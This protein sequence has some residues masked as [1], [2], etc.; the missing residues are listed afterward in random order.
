MNRPNIILLTVD[1]LRADMLGY[2]GYQRPI[3]PNIDRFAAQSV[4]FRQAI[5]AGS[6][7]QAAFPGILTSTYAS[8]YGGCL[9]PLSTERP[10]PIKSLVENGYQTAAFST[11]PLLSKTYGYHHHIKH[12]VDLLPTEKAPFLFGLKGGQPLL[13]TPWVHRLAQLF[14]QNW[15]PPKVYPTAAELN[16]VAIQWLEAHQGEPF[17]AWLHYMDVHWPYHLEET[18]TQPNEIAAAWQDLAHLHE[19][20]WYGLPVSAAQKARYVNL[21]EQAVA[22]CDAQIGKLLAHL[23]NSGL[24]ENSVII[25]VSDHGEEFLERKHWGHVEINLYDEI[26]NVPL[27]IHVPGV[28]GQVVEQQVSTLDIMPTVLELANCTPPDGMLGTS[29]SPLWQGNPA[30]YNAEVAL[31]ERWRDDVHKIAVRSA[32]FKYIWDREKPEEIELYDL[33]VDPNETNNLAAQQPK[34]VAHMHGYVQAQLQRMRDTSPAAMVAEPD[35]DAEIIA[36]LRGLGYV[37]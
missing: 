21:Y 15:R 28:A 3:T 23:A 6:W 16:E 19:V 32:R 10:S 24:A 1:T 18:L 37:E 12:F 33:V 29:L 2:A 9:G 30:G 25:L 35:L 17:F 4:R 11:S 36:R 27:I 31:S 7:T 26:L 22:Y 13:R 14:G 5:T 20:N 8:M 34:V